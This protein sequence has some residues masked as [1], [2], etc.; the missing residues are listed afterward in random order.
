[1]KNYI[2]ITL[3]VIIVTS[4]TNCKEE[5]QLNN[6]YKKQSKFD[7][8]IT[9]VSNDK[10]LLKNLNLISH[11]DSYDLINNRTTEI[12]NDSTYVYG[13]NKFLG[14]EILDLV[15]F[16]NFGLYKARFFVAPGDSIQFTVKNKKILFSGKNEMQYNFF[17]NII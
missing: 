11:S 1:M 13:L 6:S 5:K 7:V 12:I 15:S 3:L 10:G 2:M 17:D 16:G 4:F 9:G 8:I 14:Y